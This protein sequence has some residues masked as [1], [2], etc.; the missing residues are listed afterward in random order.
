MIRSAE[1]ED[2]PDLAR[3]HVTSWQAAYKGLV[4]Q[5]FLDSLDVESRTAW[6][7]RALA[8]EANLVSV[9]E[10]DGTVEGFCLAGT[11]GDAGWGEVFAIYVAPDHWGTGLGKGLLEAGE[12][13]LFSAGHERALLW[14][15]DGN[16]RARAFYQRRGWAIGK[17]IRIE[18]IGG[19]D[20]T[21]VRY[22]KSLVTA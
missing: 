20:L 7:D 12:G 14:V 6:W 10:I 1:P 11:S 15:L 21:E 8:R 18:N 19:T 22:E 4:N 2:A 9:G 3:V 16:A 13:G 17:P 5:G